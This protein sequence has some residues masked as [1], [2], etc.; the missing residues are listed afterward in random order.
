[1]FMSFEISSGPY[2]CAR[3]KSVKHVAHI[4][5]KHKRNARM[6]LF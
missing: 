5:H 2:I 4:V 3:D 6:H 1:M